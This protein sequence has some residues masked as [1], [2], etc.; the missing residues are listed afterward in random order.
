LPVPSQNVEEIRPHHVLG[1]KIDTLVILE[2]FD[3]LDYEVV[4]QLE[5]DLSLTVYMLIELLLDDFFLRDCF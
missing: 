2:R 5:E 3:Q 4:V 1:Q